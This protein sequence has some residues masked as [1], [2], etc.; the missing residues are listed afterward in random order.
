MRKN[1]GSNTAQVCHHLIPHLVTRHGQHVCCPVCRHRKHYTLADGRKKCAR[2]GKRYTPVRRMQKLSAPVLK[3]VVRLFWLMVPAERVANDL[4]INRKTVQRYFSRLRERIAEDSERVLGKLSGEIEVDESYFGGARK[5]KRG[6]GAGGKIPV[7]G[8]L[9][10]DGDVRV[11]FPK[12]VNRVTLQGAIKSH[13]RPQSWVY[14]DSFRAYNHLDLE[15]FKHRR[16]SHSECFGK[17]QVHINGIENF[18][19]F[20]KRRLKIYHGGFK[21]NFPFFMREMEYRFNHRN[22]PD[23]VNHLV[24]MLKFGPI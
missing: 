17:G 11:V 7:F 13:V 20:A 12:Q 23:V 19:G 14:S 8:L 2:C 22:D 1:K 18:W 9:K 16:I 3:E 4:G 15:G 10:R 24:K 21:K 6:R 5:G